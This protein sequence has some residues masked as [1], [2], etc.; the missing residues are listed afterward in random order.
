MQEPA[1]E[2]EEE[3]E[4]SDGVWLGSLFLIIAPVYYILGSPTAAE[5]CT[6]GF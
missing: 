2:D 3:V 6:G 5:F 1:V 4:A